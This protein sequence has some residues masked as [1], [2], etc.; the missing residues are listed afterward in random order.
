MRDR[1]IVGDYDEQ[2][3][4]LATEVLREHHL[5]SGDGSGSSFA[6]ARWRYRSHREPIDFDGLASDV[7]EQLQRLQRARPPGTDVAFDL[8]WA[9]SGILV[10]SASLML[11]EPVGTTHAGAARFVWRVS[12][13][14]SALL[15][16]DIGDLHD[17]VRNESQFWETTSQ[18]EPGTDQTCS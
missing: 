2:M 15:D 9:V 14:W 18:A 5:G 3:T 11:D 10:D 12:C 1:P 17:H 6:D 8:A 13:A 4:R 7:I 16:G